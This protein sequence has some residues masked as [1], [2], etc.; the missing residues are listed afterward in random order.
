MNEV[1]SYA[2]I[3]PKRDFYT[4]YLKKEELTRYFLT[5]F[6]LSA[7]T[8]S[9]NIKKLQESQLLM[10]LESIIE[11]MVLEGAGQVVLKN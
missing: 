8:N 10:E 1:T 3:S 2:N 7:G 11:N 9:C 6:T 5:W 4:P